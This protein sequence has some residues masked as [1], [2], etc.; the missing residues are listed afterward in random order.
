LFIL[1]QYNESLLLIRV[2][3]WF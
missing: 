2:Y 3:C 1:G